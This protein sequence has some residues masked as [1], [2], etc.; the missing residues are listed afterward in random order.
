[1]NGHNPIQID[2]EKLQ[3]VPELDFVLH[4]LFYPYGFGNVKDLKNLLLN[5]EAGKQVLSPTHILIKDNTCLWLKPN[6][7]KRSF[8]F[9]DFGRYGWRYTDP[10][11]FFVLNL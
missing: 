1:M 3:V 11:S 4:K 2:I 8:K 10:V 9:V 5:A 7:A 6:E